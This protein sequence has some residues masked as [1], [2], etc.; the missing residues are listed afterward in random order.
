VLV[1]AMVA[2]AMAV[3]ATVAAARE[4]AAMAPE[5][6]DSEAAAIWAKAAAALAVRAMVVGAARV[7][8]WLAAVDSAVM[9]IDSAKGVEDR[10]LRLFE[11]CR[12][13][14]L[15][16]MTFANKMDRPG[17]DPLDLMDE[18]GRTLKIRTV[19]LNWPIGSGAEFRGVELESVLSDGLARSL[20]GLP[21]GEGDP[22]ASHGGDPS[23]WFTVAA[24]GCGPRRLR[25]GD[26]RTG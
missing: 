22:L 17:L 19:A 7:L 18:V 20:A 12:M 5:A 21:Q 9:L 8:D 23:R 26:L 2:V 11:V 1:V 4:E 13:R 24:S 6:E 16:V 15:P 10:T 14:K 25:H 3:E